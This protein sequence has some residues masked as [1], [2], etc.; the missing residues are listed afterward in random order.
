[1]AHVR[2]IDNAIYIDGVP[3]G[4]PAN[5]DETYE[6]LRERHGMAWIVSTPTDQE[7]QSVAR[8]LALAAAQRSAGAYPRH[9]PRCNPAGPGWHQRVTPDRGL[10]SDR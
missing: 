5:L 10:G 1:M 3:S 4:A 6:L 2:V 7:I 8:E 9:P